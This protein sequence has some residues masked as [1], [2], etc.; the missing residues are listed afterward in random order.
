[1]K[2]GILSILSILLFNQ[3]IYSQNKKLNI[4]DLDSKLRASVYDMSYKSFSFC[5]SSEY[6]DV[7]S[8]NSTDNF[9]KRFQPEYLKKGC[10]WYL[11]RFG[12]IE[13]IELKAVLESKNGNKIFRYKVKREFS[14]FVNEIRTTVNK[15]GKFTG[16]ISKPYWSDKFYK[17]N[18]NPNLKEVDTAEI[19]KNIL[20]V[21]KEFA[22]NGYYK[23]E[24]SIFD[25]DYLKNIPNK[26]LAKIWKNHL[27]P[28][29]DSIKKLNGN[30]NKIKL[31]Q[32]LSDS[33]STKI[34][35][36]K[37]KF[38]NL[39]TVSEIR[40]YNYINNQHMGLFVI[41]KWFDKYKPYEKA[42]QDSKE[43]ND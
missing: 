42:V 18:E 32:V 3:I 6:P 16:I 11:S 30:F 12:T 41:N 38:N 36:Y 9:L 31:E 28:E 20:K 19:S 43:E 7:N 26:K 17:W 22:F 25:G 13:K 23:C 8:K 2:L 14:D 40:L 39:K 34:Y 15:Q 1:M 24:E 4:D 33:L 35:R 29:C 5:D 21:N 27:K 37:V 10:E